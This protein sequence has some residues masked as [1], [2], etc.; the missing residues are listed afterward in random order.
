M[1]KKFFSFLLSEKCIIEWRN[2]LIRMDRLLEEAFKLAIKN[3]LSIM[4]RA[5][6]GDG[7][8]SPVPL[9]LLRADLIDN[10]VSIKKSVTVKE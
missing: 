8:T 2:Y 6:R 3:S 5:L 9:L 10:K 7:T 1:I 4:Y